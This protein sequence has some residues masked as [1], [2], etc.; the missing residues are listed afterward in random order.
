MFLTPVH[1]SWAAAARAQSGNGCCKFRGTHDQSA[2][3]AGAW[4]VLRR[5]LFET[6]ATWATPHCG[7]SLNWYTCHRYCYIHLISVEFMLLQ[8]MP[9]FHRSRTSSAVWVCRRLSGLSSKA[10]VHQAVT[11]QTKYINDYLFLLILLLECR[12]E[13]RNCLLLRCPMN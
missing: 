5:L 3:C 9:G 1:A 11:K 8:V 10:Q 6:F 2:T 12:R 13:P 4:S 7:S